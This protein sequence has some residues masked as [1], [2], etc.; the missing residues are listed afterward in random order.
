MY[1]L[2]EMLT[3]TRKEIFIETRRVIKTKF[4][5][6]ISVIWPRFTPAATHTKKINVVSVISNLNYPRLRFSL[7]KL[8]SR[9]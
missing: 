3:G 7:R 2:Q 1:G 8:W 4:Y 9:T 6:S 5:S